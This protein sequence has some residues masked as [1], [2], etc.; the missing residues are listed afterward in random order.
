MVLQFCSGNKSEICVG[1]NKDSQDE[2]LEGCN[3][4]EFNAHYH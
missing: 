3:W 2:P 4:L 1:S